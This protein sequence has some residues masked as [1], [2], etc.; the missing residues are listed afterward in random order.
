[1]TKKTNEFCEYILDQL[2]EI[3]GLTY[4]AMFGGYGIYCDG[5][6]FAILID[7]GRLYFKVTDLNK[8]D[9]EAMK[10]TPFSYERNG[11]VISM[12]Y[13][14]IP[15]EIL[16]NSQEATRLARRAIEAARAPKPD[17]KKQKSSL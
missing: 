7:G 9:Y 10:S 15:I 3:E 4:K 8:S 5:Q 16:E 6:V 13:Y 17:K 14:E 11:K 2:S 12:S 1:M